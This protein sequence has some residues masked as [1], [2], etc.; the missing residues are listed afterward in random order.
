MNRWIVARVVALSA[1]FAAI[2]MPARAQVEISGSYQN[3]MFEDYIEHGP[4]EFLGNFTGM[5]LSDEGR[6]KALLY[7]SNVPSMY[8]RNVSRS[9]SPYF[10]TGPVGSISTKSSTATARCSRGY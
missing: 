3:M 1:A 4:G 9:P 2:S 7:T 5:P 10:C 6:A 8:E